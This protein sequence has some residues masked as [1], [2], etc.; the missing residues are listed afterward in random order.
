MCGN[1]GCGDKNSGCSSGGCGSGSGCC[2]EMS[3]EK[4]M[5]GMFMEIADSA[6][7]K[8]A[9]EKMKA[10]WER[11]IGKD[12]EKM[13]EFFVEQSSMKWMNEEEWMQN[14]QKAMETFG[15]M[16]EEKKKK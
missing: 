6:W 10:H 5:F 3:K 12:M 9:K 1:C 11:K 7:M 8:L 4:M 15:K 2:G 14:K 13:A 16:M